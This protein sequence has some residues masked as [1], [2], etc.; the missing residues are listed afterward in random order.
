MLEIRRALPEDANQ[1]AQ[2]GRIGFPGYP[3]IGIYDEQTIAASINQG[4]LRWVATD[5]ERIIA[6]AVLGEGQMAEIKRVVVH[7][8]YRGNGAAK[9][10]TRHLCNEAKSLGL[11]T[12]TDARSDQ[13]GM[14][15]SA[16]S[17]GLIA[18][19]LESGKHVV[20]HHELPTGA[21]RETMVHL[22]GLPT[23]LSLLRKS[24]DHLDRHVPGFKNDLLDAMSNSFTPAPKNSSLAETKLP[25][26]NVVRFE[27]NAA[28]KAAFPQYSV[29]NDDVSNIPLP[30]CDMVV[31]SPDRSAFLNFHSL[32]V[33]FDLIT[34]LLVTLKLQV[35]S[36]YVP[37]DNLDILS[38]ICAAGFQPVMIR[39]WITNRN[40]PVVWQVGT[41][42]TSSDFDACHH[43][44]SLTE[45]VE[46]QIKNTV[47]SIQ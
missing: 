35:V 28:L 22:T 26:A 3:F 18:V 5:V 7:P 4:E 37:L 46:S 14:Q 45:V 17:A 32:D 34:Q 40:E 13:P 38:K 15:S 27:V 2:L 29:G 16:T 6:T 21:A 30:G 11:N 42:L 9:Q 24:L 19:C 1:I 23:D 36:S 31:I 44:T 10:L 39:P 20:Y 41:R 25:S 43:T 12:W 33:N 47:S 8:D